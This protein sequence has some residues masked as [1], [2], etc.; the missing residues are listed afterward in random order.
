[1]AFLFPFAPNWAAPYKVDSAYKTEII[2]NRDYG[3]QRFALRTQPR[4]KLSFT[5]SPARGRLNEF[6]SLMAARQQAE[7]VVPEITRQWQTDGEALLGTNVVVT[8]G[9][10]IP[11]WVVA[12]AYVVF[13][14]SAGQEMQ[15]VVSADA[16]GIVLDQPLAATVASGSRFYPGLCGRFDQALR[17]Q[18]LTN[19][20]GQFILNFDADPGLN[21]HEADTVA[22]ATMVGTELFLMRPNWRTSPTV[23]LD[24][25]LETTDYARGRVTR[26]SSVN[27]NDVAL[28]FEFMQRDSAA[29]EALSQFFHR[30][31]GQQGAFYAP[32][33]GADFDL[34]VGAAPG[35]MDFYVP[36]VD[37]ANLFA[38]SPVYKAAIVFFRDGTYGV[39]RIDSIAPSGGQS[40]V[41]FFSPWSRSV[42]E[43]SVRLMCWLP[44]WRLTVDT[45]T[46]DWQTRTVAQAQLTMKT[47]RGTP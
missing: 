20:A 45:L 36:G 27:F 31:K 2:T 19:T 25:L 5:V 39:K 22:P 44:L 16:M 32:T 17:G 34:S 37:F 3:E 6:M 47:L 18:F 35:S 7:F 43:E 40:R 41:R 24:G 15:L 46:L 10:F 13:E 12:G 33:W 28:R 9:G 23:S 21:F 11:P 42:N 30:Q 4:R 29:A 38:A 26:F 1:M 8:E 14:G